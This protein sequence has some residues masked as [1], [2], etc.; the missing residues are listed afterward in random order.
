MFLASRSGD[1]DIDF[2]SGAF[3]TS[4]LAREKKKQPRQKHQKNS[5]ALLENKG[6]LLFVLTI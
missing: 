4:D 6:K 1:R 5:F 2:F 3:L